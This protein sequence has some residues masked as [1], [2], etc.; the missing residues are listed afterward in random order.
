[1]S[2]ITENL[3]TIVVGAVVAI[4]FFTIVLKGIKNKKDGKHSCS[5]GCEGCGMSDVCH[6]KTK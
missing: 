3:G 4:I 5:C 6:K 1:M 2:F